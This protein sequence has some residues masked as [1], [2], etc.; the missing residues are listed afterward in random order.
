MRMR[1]IADQHPVREPNPSR[2][3][4]VPEPGFCILAEAMLIALGPTLFLR[5]CVEALEQ[6]QKDAS[7]DLANHHN[8][9]AWSA[10]S[11]S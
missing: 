1:R 8:A 10:S 2:D 3:R 5:D 7:V 9:E 6:M 11:R 4:I